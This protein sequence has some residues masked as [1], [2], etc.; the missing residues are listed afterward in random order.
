MDLHGVDN[1]IKLIKLQNQK[2]NVRDISVQH[3]LKFATIY[4]PST[5]KDISL[6]Y[7]RN[8]EYN[9]QLANKTSKKV[10]VKQSY[11]FMI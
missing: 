3:T 2:S 11:I 10:L 6:F 9:S 7:R 4:I 5:I 1:S 8:L